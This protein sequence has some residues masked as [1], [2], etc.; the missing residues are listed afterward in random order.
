VDVYSAVADATLIA[1]NAVRATTAGHVGKGQANAVNTSRIVALATA[2]VT[3]GASGTFQTNGVVI[4]TTGEWDA[5]T[6]GSGGLTPD[7]EY[8]LSATTAGLLTTTA[9][10]T[11]G[12]VVKP[13]GV[14]LSTTE[15]ALRI[16]SEVL[17]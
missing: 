8:F 10:T 17:L 16:L 11:A 12:H 9:P 3:S 1:G 7:S 13:L 6:G 4:L 14:A 5:V 15:L 2:G